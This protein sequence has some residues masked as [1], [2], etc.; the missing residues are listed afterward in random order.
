MLYIEATQNDQELFFKEGSAMEV[1]YP[2]QEVKEGM[3]LFLGE[4]DHDEAMDWVLDENE[5]RLQKKPL[6]F[7]LKYLLEYKLPEI[8]EPSISFSKMISYPSMPRKPYDA[9]Q[10]KLPI[11]EKINLAL[12]K[13]QKIFMSKKKKEAKREMLFNKKVKRYEKDLEQYE[14]AHAK[15]L[16]KKAA[17]DEAVPLVKQAQEDWKKE[18]NKRLLKIYTFKIKKKDYVHNFRMQNALRYVKKNYGKKPD[19]VLFKIFEQIYFGDIEV[20]KIKKDAAHALAFGKELDRV[21]KMN[22]LKGSHLDINYYTGSNIEYHKIVSS[23]KRKLIEDEFAQTGTMK[24]RNINNYIASVNQFGW[25]NVDRF[26]KFDKNMLA[27]VRI[28]NQQIT[29]KY[30]CILKESRSILRPVFSKSGFNFAT[31]P[32]GQAFKIIG[33]KLDNGKPQMAVREFSLNKAMNISMEFTD[34][35]LEEIKEEFAGLESYSM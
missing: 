16:I 1:V 5:V 13:G 18:M 33:I 6:P 8:E 4:T 7:D 29:T 2:E 30:Y 25:I 26:L 31:L 20:R 27:S 32:K 22:E 35:S 21:I 3:Q 19:E 17:Y 10:P 28:P 23:I 14:E 15:Y 12:T 24:A 34:I 9:R 11:K